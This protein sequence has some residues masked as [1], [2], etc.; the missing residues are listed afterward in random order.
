MQVSTPLKYCPELHE[1]H[2]LDPELV[3]PEPLQTEQKYC[4]VVFWYVPAGQAR[5]EVIWAEGQ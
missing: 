4:P 3:A 1:V 2:V 5:G